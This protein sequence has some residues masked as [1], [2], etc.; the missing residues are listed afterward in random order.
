MRP[1]GLPE[2]PLRKPPLSQCKT[3][4]IDS[5]LALCVPKHLVKHLEYVTLSSGAGNTIKSQ[6]SVFPK[7]SAELSN[8]QAI[9]IVCPTFIGKSKSDKDEA[10]IAAFLDDCFG[11]KPSMIVMNDQQLSL[12]HI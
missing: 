3:T 9:M 10:R 4:S 12:I 1:D 7:L 8:A 5:T 6:M 11:D 2:G